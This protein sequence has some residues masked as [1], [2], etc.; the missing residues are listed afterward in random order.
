MIVLNIVILNLEVLAIS[1]MYFAIANKF[2]YFMLK[3]IVER[4]AEIMNCKN[5]RK[6]L[7]KDEKFCSNCGTQI[8]DNN[9]I[10]K[11]FLFSVLSLILF[12]IT[13]LLSFICIIKFII[14]GGS[15]GDGWAVQLFIFQIFVPLSISILLHN[16]SS[17]SIKNH[18][19]NGFN[20][21]K[22]LKILNTIN[23]FQL[24]LFIS[25]FVISFF[26]SV[27]S[28]NTKKDA[29]INQ[30]LNEIYNSNYEIINHCSAY[31]NLE[32]VTFVIENFDYPIS[33][34]FNWDNNDYED[35]YDELKQASYLNYHSYINSI[36]NDDIISL[37]ELSKKES[38]DMMY[39]SIVLTSDY[40]NNTEILISKIK[41]ISNQYILQFPNNSFYFQIFFIDKIDK[42]IK[43]DYYILMSQ[44]GS[45]EDNKKITSSIN[46]RI[47]I[48]FDKNTNI[49]K[50]IYDSIY[51]R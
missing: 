24:P 17:N 44:Y 41:Q 5:C 47:H 48:Y 23:K 50:E 19:K 3:L 9:W 46:K 49:D 1:F 14:K 10:K 12:L 13:L 30:K 21:P 11:G 15:S 20:V 25:I 26:V 28:K 43:Q 35:N 4:C 7:N 37:M 45:C 22:T 40:L 27:V 18:I 6:I 34:R 29:V 51:N 36:F 2:I 32:H 16:S 42:K 38:Y 39:L 33:S 31:P 8:E